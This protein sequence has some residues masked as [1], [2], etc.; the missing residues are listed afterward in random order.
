MAEI[1]R[2]LKYCLEGWINYDI[3]DEHYTSKFEAQQE[4][5]HVSMQHF[6][7]K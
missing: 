3:K 7:S 1:H 6:V 2:G 5:M 4:S